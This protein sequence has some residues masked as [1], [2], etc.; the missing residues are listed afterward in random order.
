MYIANKIALGQADV[1]VGAGVD[2][3]SD[4]PLVVSERLRRA[5][6]RAN[7]AKTI[8]QRLQ[9]IAGIRP[10]D[11]APVPPRVVEPRTGLSMGQH[12]A[13]TTAAWSIPRD[14]QDEFALASHQRLAQA[15]AC[16][17]YTSRCV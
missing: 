14:A 16:L 9:A 13:A 17:L 4:A 2:S 11:L 15:W 1:G 7:R 6:L 8:P 5:V 3:A 12:Q 10:R